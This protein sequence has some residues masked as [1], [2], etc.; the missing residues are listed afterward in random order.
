MY[1]LD[2]NK[3]CNNSGFVEMVNSLFSSYDDIDI[4]EKAFEGS[5]EAESLGRNTHDYALYT[6]AVSANGT[7][8]LC[9]HS[10][11]NLTVES[12]QH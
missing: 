6:Y 4:R 1:L 10:L 7:G 9:A 5:K 8:Y 12:L 3:P 2:F 11:S